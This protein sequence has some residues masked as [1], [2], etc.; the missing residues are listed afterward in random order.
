VVEPRVYDDTALPI[1]YRWQALDFMRMQWPGLFSDDRRLHPTIY[2]PEAN[3]VHVLIGEGDVLI[4]YATVIPMQLDH[5]A[6]TYNV[7]GL[8]NV[9]TYP[10][11]RGEGYGGRVVAA[12]TQFIKASDADVAALFCSPDKTGFYS[13][14]GWEAMKEAS[15]WIGTAEHATKYETWRMMMFLSPTGRAAREAFESRPW[16]LAHTW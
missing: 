4:S 12:A 5:D 7:H 1:H 16:Y 15:T 2:P 8:A 9:L 14:Q 3:P 10:S 13:R 6:Q 11:F